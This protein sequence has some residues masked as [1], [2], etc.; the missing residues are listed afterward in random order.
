M[1]DTCAG[2]TL[3]TV[4]GGALGHNGRDSAMMKQV[5]HSRIRSL[6]DE[7][8][9]LRVSEIHDRLD[10]SEA[11]IRRD[12]DEMAAEGLIRRTHGGAMATER[13]GPRSLHLSRAVGNAEEK[14]SIGRAAASMIYA[15]DTVFIGSGTTA[16]SV[17]SHVEK[18]AEVR[19]ITNSLPVI[20][21]LAGL[22]HIELFVV[23]GQVD[24]FAGAMRTAVTVETIE[25][26]RADHVVLGIQGISLDSG[27]TTDSMDNAAIDRAIMSIS[28]NRII[29]A[30]HTKFGQV[31]AFTVGPVSDASVVVTSAL[32]PASDLL[33]ITSAGAE[34]LIAE[35]PSE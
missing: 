21:Q 31:E 8:G 14:A 24:H 33:S 13:L 12:L 28:S 10:V 22:N 27:L 35:R 16:A 26:Y 20:N 7:L 4:T 6:I 34:T 19:V 30:D 25:R 18:L 2:G 11:T 23:G 15:G 3:R 17:A 1:T 29:V 9:Q 32:V 5:R